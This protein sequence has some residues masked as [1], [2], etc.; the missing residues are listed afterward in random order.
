M[1][2]QVEKVELCLTAKQDAINDSISRSN[3]IDDVKSASGKIYTEL[4][5][6]LSLTQCGNTTISFLRDTM[7]TLITDETVV[8]KELERQLFTQKSTNS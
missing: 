4:K 6:I 8:F 5:K 3:P 2:G 1:N 7:A